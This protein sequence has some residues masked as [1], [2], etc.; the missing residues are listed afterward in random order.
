MELFLYA[1]WGELYGF[2][3][4]G[5]PPLAVQI[6]AFNTIFFMLWIARRMRNAPAL[7][8]QTANVVQALLVAVNVLI[9]FQHDIKNLLDRYT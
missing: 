3:S 7:R 1:R 5:D 2:L 4:R 8:A 6:L 9:I